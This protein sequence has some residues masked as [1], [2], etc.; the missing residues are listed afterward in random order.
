MIHVIRV[1]YQTIYLSWTGV[2]W[3]SFCV[4]IVYE[5]VLL[6]KGKFSMLNKKTYLE[7]VTLICL[8]YSFCSVDWVSRCMWINWIVGN[9]WRKIQGLSIRYAAITLILLLK[10]MP[11]LEEILPTNLQWILLAINSAINFSSLLS[12]YIL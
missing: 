2:F 10:I 12:Y 8:H 1:F 4:H 11:S 5:I 3:F 6:E 9:S 7:N